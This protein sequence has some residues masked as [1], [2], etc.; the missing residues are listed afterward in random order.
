[1]AARLSPIS[2]DL[3]S[4]AL[5]EA[6]QALVA[7][8]QAIAQQ[9]ARIAKLRFGGHDTTQAE[10]LLRTLLQ[11]QAMDEEQ[12]VRLRDALQSGA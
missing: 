7:G 1:M 4:K 3:L 12:C 8:Q 5:V 2:R 6:E 9:Q 11:A 10:Q